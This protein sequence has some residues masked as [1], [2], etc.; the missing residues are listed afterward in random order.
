MTSTTNEYERRYLTQRSSKEKI[1]FSCVAYTEE[2]SKYSI[3]ESRRLTNVDERGY[4]VIKEF[5]KSFAIRVE[6][7][8]ILL[9]EPSRLCSKLISPSD[10]GTQES[11]EKYGSLLEKAMQSQ[12]HEEV[13]SDCDDW[14]SKQKKQKDRRP[15]LTSSHSASHS[16]ITF[17]HSCKS[18]LFIR[19]VQHGLLFL[20]ARSPK[21]FGLCDTP[22]GQHRVRK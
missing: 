3:V 2:P 4:G 13:P 17:D 5:G 12:M 6:Q 11:M 18:S 1:T 14:H 16:S 22:P 19:I 20:V 9:R 21:R 10:L 7:T 8:G 15:G